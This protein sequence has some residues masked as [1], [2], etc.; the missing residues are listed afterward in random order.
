MVGLEIA[1]VLGLAV[2][3][4]GL[5]KRWLRVPAPWAWTG[6]GIGLSFLPGLHDVV[7]PP[8]VVLYLFL[9]ALLYWESL[10]ISWQRFRYDLR[11]ILLLSVGL[12]F[13]TAAA[14]AGIGGLFGLALPVA[15][16][17]G[18]VLSPT[19][20]TAVSAMAPPLPRRF[21]TML[22]G[23]SLVNDGSA[24]A[25][26]SVAVAAVVASRDVDLGEI[27]WRFVLAV[28]VGVVAGLV[29]GYLLYLLRRISRQPMLAGTISV[30]S[31]FAL[32]LP[33]ETLHGSGVVAVV[34]GGL[35]LGRLM[36]RVVSAQARTLG[37]D[38]WRVAT[39][40][41]NG[42]LFVLIGLQARS[43]IEAFAG[44]GWPQVVGLT[45][46]VTAAI[47]LVR[48]LWILVMAPLIRL[49]DRRP[50]QRGRRAPF[51]VRA[52]LVWGGFRGAV[53]LAAALSVPVLIASGGDF[54]QRELIIA[55]T[56]GVIVLLLVV[57]GAT[58]PLVVRAAR[59]SGDERE[60]D[61]HRLALETAV[62]SALEHLEADAS[63]AQVSDDDREEVRD[64]LTRAL[65]DVR[66]DD[67][68]HE[69]RSDD[70]VRR[71]LLRAVQRK[72]DAIE[73]LRQQKRIDD[74]VFLDVQRELDH[75]ELR[76]HDDL[77]A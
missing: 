38:F 36:P 30:L 8:D 11:V 37:F 7:L 20:A 5:A 47:F 50:S 58:M 12:V 33:A 70:G 2:L 48:F 32:Y 45:L 10:A 55:V 24:L 46:A 27:S 56:F 61:E 49:L 71:L 22:K 72:R 54:P 9:P 43:V 60:R 67:G 75:E 74:V 59:L 18:A 26:Y 29:V 77:E 1:L 15:L 14:V 34:T 35:L 28:L 21:D 3:A 69:G 44:D 40:V 53:S 76:L 52:V 23:E 19:D 39:Y 65:D 17:L 68:R 6:I 57:Q 4:G 16:V 25:L 62:E 73:T 31:P 64:R 42:A 63:D 66:R 51:R 13:A 41:I